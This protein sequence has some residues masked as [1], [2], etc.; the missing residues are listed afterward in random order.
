MLHSIRQ[1]IEALQDPYGLTRTLGEIEV[2]RSSDGEP[3]R[4]VGNSAVVFKIRCGGRYKMLKCY[5]RP[6]EHLEAIYQEKL[7]RQEL[8]VWQAD[9]QG[10][11]CDVVID[12]WI[13]GITLYEAV[14]R[15]AGSGDKAHLSNLA[16][17]FDRLALELLE[18]DWAHGDL[19]PENIL[20]D[21]SGT[22]RPV[23]FDAMFLPVFAGEKSPELGT[24]AYQ[25]PGRTAEDFDASIDDYSIA[26]ISTTLHA[27]RSSPD[28]SPATT[29]ERDCCSRPGKSSG[30]AVRPTQNAS[31]CSK[32][33]AMPSAIASPGCSN[34][35]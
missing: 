4:W 30:T 29:G 12:D 20:L 28:C 18:S 11:W 6:M 26:T 9:G 35:R 33:R 1:F 7:L 16:R 21:E 13:E 22:L 3:L 25:H 23:D 19:K 10:E 31:H 2:C 5:T 15:G 8:Y 17:Q 14:M 27:L 32:R 24:A 34:P